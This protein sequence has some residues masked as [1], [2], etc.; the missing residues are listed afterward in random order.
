MTT[1]AAE[2]MGGHGRVCAGYAGKS[3]N[4]LDIT[5]LMNLTDA[6]RSSIITMPLT[7]LLRVRSL[8]GPGAAA[9]A[10]KKEGAEDGDDEAGKGEAE[11]AVLAGAAGTH[12]GGNG[13]EN[14]GREAVERERPEGW[15][16]RRINA[17]SPEDIASLARPGEGFTSL[18]MAAPVLD[19]VSTLQTL[20][21]LLAPS[22]PFAVWAYAAAPLA[23]ALED[24]RSSHVAVN[25]SLTEPWL[26]ESQVLPGRTH[27]TMTTQAGAGGYVLSGNYIPPWSRGGKRRDEGREEGGACGKKARVD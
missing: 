18:V 10:T 11:E 8:S 2:R 7:E 13:N 23:E 27:P 3:C 25:L 14:R 15:V 4:S 26:R 5:R 6:E 9:T 1:A 17:A 24:L 20:L 21:P 12:D 22:A 16:S 19:P